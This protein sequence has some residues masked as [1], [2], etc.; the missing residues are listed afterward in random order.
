MRFPV[1][2][3]RNAQNAGAELIRFGKVAA[4]ACAL[5]C[6]LAAL[7]ATL[8][9]QRQM[10]VAQLVE[11]VRSF[12]HQKNDDRKAADFIRTIKL[13]NKLDDATVEQLQ[14]E[15]AGP[16]TVA[17]L[18]ALTD[19]TANLPPAPPPQAKPAPVVIPAPSP[20]EQ[21]RIL[22]EVKEHALNYTKT[23]PDFI[24]TQVTRRY[25]DS[26][27]S[28]RWAQQDTIQEHLSYV[29][30]HEEYKVVMVN[31]KPAVN[32]G[33]TKLGGA[34]SSG[35]F[36]TMLAEIFAPATRT[37]FH[38]ERWAKLRGRI[39]YVFN[40]KVEQA[41]SKYSIYHEGSNREIVSGYHGLIYADRD[42]GM[43]MRIMMQCDT[44][45]PDFP[46]QQVKEDLNYD[47]VDIS[48]RQFVLPVK[49]EL[50]SAE[51]RLRNRNDIEFRLY[52]KFSTESSITFDTPDPT[53][54]PLSDD[55]F[56]EEPAAPPPGPA[57]NE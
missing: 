42:T 33:H 2:C 12:I 5:G 47:F 53:P 25:V 23:L 49:V 11:M 3:N 48:G 46:I 51:L 22:D 45:P 31:D 44:I 10:T 14:Q 4:A 9:A 19:A 37:E 13:T 38:W 16:K 54:E 17:A 55:N 21:S 35:E 28:G 41:N 43:V 27:G 36:G 20:A 34:T 57:K 56:K 18:R 26:T 8:Y 50:Q 1:F 15:G 7:S 52:R 6:V 39:M 30:G 29:D 32:I 24:C 40:F